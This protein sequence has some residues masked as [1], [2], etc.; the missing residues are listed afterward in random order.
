MTEL[1]AVLLTG[2]GVVAGVANTLA[3]GGSTVTLP[4]LLSCGVSA[5]VANGTNHLAHFIGGAARVSAFAYS[6]ALRWR[7]ALIL[8]IPSAVGAVAGAWLATLLPPQRM[9]TIIIVAAFVAAVLM[10]ANPKRFLDEKEGGQP[11]LGPGQMLLLFLVGAWTGFVVLEGGTFLLLALTL[12]VGYGLVPAV[13]AKAVI[14]FLSM[15]FATAVF[16]WTGEID[17][18]AALYL[19]TGTVIGSWLTARLALHGRAKVWLYWSVVVFVWAEL[20]HL[21]IREMYSHS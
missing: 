7:S 11:R 8:T 21:V 15:I 14:T 16:V 9:E 2:G 20:I 13:A 1:E 18:P 6:D 4:L 19:S 10:V 17:G 12:G 5:P 3:G